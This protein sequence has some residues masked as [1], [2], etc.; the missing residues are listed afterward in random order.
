VEPS[1]AEQVPA[2]MLDE[3]AR[4]QMC[5]KVVVDFPDAW[6]K[7]VIETKQKTRALDLSGRHDRWESRHLDLPVW[8]RSEHALREI[9]NRGTA[10]SLREEDCLAVLHSLAGDPVVNL[11]L[12]VCLKYQ[13]LPEDILGDLEEQE[14]AF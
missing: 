13:A 6:R 9:I 1:L 3:L 8:I 2:T 10:S 5:E 4:F 14:S 12:E 11:V 7:N